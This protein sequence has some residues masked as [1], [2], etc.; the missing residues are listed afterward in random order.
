MARLD[1][2]RLA[3]AIVHEGKAPG[4]FLA[5]VSQVVCQKSV[6]AYLLFGRDQG[7]AAT[8][9]LCRAPARRDRY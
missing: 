4:H 1:D 8:N 6:L 9:V 7:I 5:P 2:R 3:R